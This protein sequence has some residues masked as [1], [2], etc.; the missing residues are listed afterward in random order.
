[1]QDVGTIFKISQHSHDSSSQE[2][3]L[4]CHFIS[5]SIILVQ[6]TIISHLD[7]ASQL[8]CQKVLVPLLYC[9][10]KSC[11]KN[12]KS[13]HVLTWSWN[14]SIVYHYTKNKPE[15]LN[16]THHI[17]PSPQPC[18]LLKPHIMPLFPCS[19][20]SILSGVLFSPWLQELRRMDAIRPIFKPTYILGKGKMLSNILK[21]V[22]HKDIF[23]AIKNSSLC[24]FSVPQNVYGKMHFWVQSL[25]KK[26]YSNRK[27]NL[28]P[29]SHYL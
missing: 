24:H 13:D 22:S 5:T 28:G 9:S 6:T 27:W 14:S 2:E 19:L 23:I 26:L 20:C 21:F 10:Y 3:F 4:K 12:I 11:F 1:M 16:L 15:I 29:G 7:T 25:W 18:F 8:V 17:P